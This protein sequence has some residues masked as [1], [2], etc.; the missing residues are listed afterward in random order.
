MRK[1]IQHGAHTDARTSSG[2]TVLSLATDKIATSSEC[3]EI[4]SY[5]IQI[6]TPVQSVPG[7][8]FLVKSRLEAAVKSDWS[9]LD[10][11]VH[12]GDSATVEMLLR[13]R[14]F[15]HLFP[16]VSEFLQSIMRPESI[17][18]RKSVKLVEDYV[19]EMKVPSLL[20]QCR[21]KLRLACG[22]RLQWYVKSTVMPAALRS[23]LLLEDLFGSLERQTDT[24][25][26]LDMLDSS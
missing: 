6:G 13:S 11:A 3:R 5:L 21:D 26:G 9:L 8:S 4:V 14:H 1:L 2:E 24:E 12:A 7:L 10:L 15:P 23:Y 25:E 16:K 17:Q 20:L 18:Q 19:A 22:I